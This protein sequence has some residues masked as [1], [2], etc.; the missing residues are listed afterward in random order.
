MF[1][2][3][4]FRQLEL[5]PDA[6][7]LDLCAAPGGKTTD[8]AASL[9]ER[10]GDRYS[11]IANEVMKSRFGVLRSNVETWGD[12]RVGTVSRDPSAFGD[13]P[14]F[15]AIVADVPCSGEGHVPQRRA[16]RSGMVAPDGGILRRPFPPHPA[17]H[18]GHPQEGRLPYLLHLHLQ[19][20]GKRRHRSL[21]A[22]GDWGPISFRPGAKHPPS[23]RKTVT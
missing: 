17:G 10:F 18:L 7:V 2:G 9:R 4:L 5:E 3:H 14:L 11:L 15:D 21:D 20:P 22:S 12:P 16:G 23:A 1:V 19:P 8:L 6:L 13:T